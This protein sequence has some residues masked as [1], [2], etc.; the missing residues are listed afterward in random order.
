MKKKKKKK[1]DEKKGKKVEKKRKRGLKGVPPETGRK[2]V[3]FERDVK[4]NPNEIEA[5]KNQILITIQQ[6]QTGLC[7]S[8]VR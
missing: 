1:K 7:Y 2:I 6:G 5:Q 3:F 4:R 8:F